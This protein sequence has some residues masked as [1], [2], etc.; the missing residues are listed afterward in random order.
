MH[1]VR[2]P[3]ICC[4]LCGAGCW[5]VLWSTDSQLTKGAD[6]AAVMGAVMSG[7]D[8]PGAEDDFGVVSGEDNLR[9]PEY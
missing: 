7:E 8:N 6:A 2:Q 4:H 9:K 1:L 3:P 5:R